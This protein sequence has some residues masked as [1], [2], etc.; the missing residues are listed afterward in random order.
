MI[1]KI[2]TIRN[3]LT[4][5]AMFAGIAEISG[6]AVLPFISDGN[7]STYVWFLMVFPVLLVLLFFLTLNFNHKVLYAP[8]DFKNEENFFKPFASASPAERAEKLREEVLEIENEETPETMQAVE[9]QSEQQNVTALKDSQRVIRSRYLLAEELVIN[10]FSKEFGHELARGVR[11][12]TPVPSYVFD[13][14]SFGKDKVTAI[15]IK[16][17]RN[18]RSI[19]TRFRDTIQRILHTAESLPDSVRGRFSLII[20]IATDSLSTDHEQLTNRLYSLIGETQ[21]SVEV[22]I[23]SLEELEKEFNLVS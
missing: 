3:P 6:T 21:F 13:A 20:A 17:V 1:E 14:V 16:Y 15:E 7:Q 5:I 23:F 11:F 8:S 4:I 18:V 19:V 12:N 10:K 22:R 2:G 9:P